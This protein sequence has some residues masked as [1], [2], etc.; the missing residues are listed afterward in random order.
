MNRTIKEIINNLKKENIFSLYGL[1]YLEVTHNNMRI[2]LEEDEETVS[3]LFYRKAPIM[4]RRFLTIRMQADHNDYYADT[5]ISEE[6]AKKILIDIN[7]TEIL[8]SIDK[9]AKQKIIDR[10]TPPPPSCFDKITQKIK[11]FKKS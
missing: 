11:I 5:T 10:D 8:I 6:T 4:D 2:L 3:L 7:I 1:N 9:A